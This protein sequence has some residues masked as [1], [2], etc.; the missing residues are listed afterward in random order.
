[1]LSRPTSGRSGHQ[2][3]SVDGVDLVAASCRCSSVS[4]G[5]TMSTRS[6]MSTPSTWLSASTA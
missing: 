2:W 6:T 1:M 5:S 4:C 3:T